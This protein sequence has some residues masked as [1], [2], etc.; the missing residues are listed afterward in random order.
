MTSL[1]GKIRAKGKSVHSVAREIDIDDC[2][3]FNY[4][5][6]RYSK[7]SKANR[8]KIRLHFISIGVL[9]APK[10]RPK[11]DCP[12]CNKTHTIKKHSHRELLNVEK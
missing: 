1:A 6:R 5:A 8:K 12:L 10:P 4:I 3:V 11:H 2:H 7:I 9:P